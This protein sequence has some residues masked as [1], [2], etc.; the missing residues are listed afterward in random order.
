VAFG[1]AGNVDDE[2][3][4][5]ACAE[6]PA[7]RTA[8]LDPAGELPWDLSQDTDADRSPCPA[9][10]PQCDRLP[11]PDLPDEGDEGVES[12]LFGLSDPLTA[13]GK[14]RVW[15]SGRIPYKFAVNTSGNY[16]VNSTTRDRVRQ[17]M[18]NYE[19]LTEGRIRFRAKTSSDTAYVVIREGSPRV[20]PH[21][22]YRSGQKQ[23]MYLRDSEYITVIKHELGHVVG[24]HHE[25]KRSDRTSSIQV[26]T[27]NIVDSS[28]CRYQFSVC[29]DCRKVG[30]YNKT[31]VMHYRTSELSD[32]RTGPVLLNLNDSWIDH[33]WQLNSKDLSAIATMY[34]SSAAS[35]PG[36]GLPD[37][38]SL[39][40]GG[41]C[42]GVTGASTV[43]GAPI[44]TAACNASGEQSWRLTRDGQLRVQHSLGCTAVAGCSAPGAPVE[45]AACSASA[46][47]QKWNLSDVAIVDSLDRCAAWQ[48]GTA[49]VGIGACT[50]SAGEQ[51]GYDAVAEALVIGGQ[52]LTA[53][54]VGDTIAI[55]PCDGGAGQRWFQ[56]R[57]G[58]VSGADTGACLAVEANGSRLALAACTDTVDQR[59]ALRGPIRDA[60]AGLCLEAGADGSPLA[61]AACDGS[62]GQVWTFWSR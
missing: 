11:G 30:S 42:A 40:A 44:A 10:D 24:L 18:T 59:F 61:L 23:Y 33:Y 9:G 41:L 15:P 31:S 8:M 54:A 57:G 20:S 39:I 45:Q 29:S 27:G 12:A 3:D 51:F 7:A 52:C 25:H 36:D 1:C 55:A 14:Y 50:G 4:D 58:F 46:P 16:E 37:G 21:V 47:D 48:P 5:L 34:G 28:N 62:A 32:C 19:T 38:G 60:R 43:D 53:G 2:V 17:A 49:D 6:D 13:S 26:R 22:G 56:A 35:L